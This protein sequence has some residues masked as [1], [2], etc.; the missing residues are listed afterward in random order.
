[1][2][3]SIRSIVILAAVASLALTGLAQAKTSSVSLSPSV[4]KSSTVFKLKL[5]GQKFQTAA[6]TSSY[7]QANLVAPKG[8]DSECSVHQGFRYDST[9]SG[10]RYKGVFT[11][12][13]NELYSQS[14]CKG[15]W[16]VKVVAVTEDDQGNPTESPLASASFRVR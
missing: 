8:A 6:D 11:L 10:A 7:L 4:G 9:G 13:P 15:T 2:F 12:D 3:R 1:M 5:A 14:W 16:K